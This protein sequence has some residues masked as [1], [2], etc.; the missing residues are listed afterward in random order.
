MKIGDAMNTILIIEDDESIN[1]LIHE[2]LSKEGYAC[3]SGF[4]G[5]EAKLLLAQAR[6]DIV[7]LDLMLPGIRGEDIL[8][9]IKHEYHIPVLLAFH[10]DIRED[11][12][13]NAM[14]ER[15]YTGDHARFQAN[16]G[17]GLA[18]VKELVEKLHG[19]VKG[20]QIDKHLCITLS[21]P[22]YQES[23]Q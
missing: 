21:F 23:M 6:F 8:W 16:T 17:L 9:I 3:T 14:F 22:I 10:N 2:Y 18:I 13:V 5:T 20:E 7:L 4:S 1:N 12:D 19:R 15:F 11:I